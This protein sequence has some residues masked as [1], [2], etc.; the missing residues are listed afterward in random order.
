MVKVVGNG[1]LNAAGSAFKPITFT[2]RHKTQDKFWK[3]IFFGSANSSNKLLYTHISYAGSSQMPDMNY[4]ANVAVSPNAR[5]TVLNSTLEKGLGWG[6]VAEE[7]SEVNQDIATVNYYDDFIDGLYKL[8]FSDPETTQLT[9]EWMDSWSFQ[10]SRLTVAGNYYDATS[11]TWF[12]GASSPWQMTGTSGFGL[13]INEDGSYLWTIAEQAPMTG[14]GAY[15]AEY[16]KGNYQQGT[17]E[18]V[19]TES[20]WRS[21]FYNDCAPDQNVDTE[22]ETGTMTLRYEINKMYNL[23]TGS[24]SWELKLINPDNSFFTYYRN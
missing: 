5:A 2:S 21:K 3:G 9:G 14:C 4:K 17:N 20:Y 6:L 18:I 13:K 11:G 19:F 8:P 24:V 12:N 7:G 16:I 22:V 23:F 15:S 1:F 10:N